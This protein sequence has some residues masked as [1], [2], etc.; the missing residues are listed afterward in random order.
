MVTIEQLEQLPLFYRDTIREEYLD[1]MGHMNVRWYIAIFDEAAWKFFD[2]IGMDSE[3]FEREQAG[4]FALQQFIR[5]LVEV[6]V[7]ESVAIRIRVIGRTAKRIHL[8]HFMI[9]E[10]TG[11]LAATME[12]LGA[13]A[14]MTVRRT[15]P[16]PP[17]VA[18]R[19]DAR[20]AEHNLLDWESPLS[21]AINL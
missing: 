12:V 9:N 14:D 13:H 15:S 4:G 1:V 6:R 5:Y 17:H 3:Y 10:T 8:M 18:S 11:K 16:Y 19:I 21:G 20:A 2:S 7:G